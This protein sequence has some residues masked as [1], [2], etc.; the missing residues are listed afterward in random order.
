MACYVPN[1]R[2]VLSLLAGAACPQFARAAANVD[3]A[4]V[5]AVDCSYSISEY[6][7][8]LQMRGLG[9][10]FLDSEMLDLVSHGLRGKI[11]ISAFLW[12]DPKGQQLIVPWR[13]LEKAGDT[14]DIGTTLLT[15]PR[16]LNAGSTSTGSALLYAAQLLQHAP[17]GS[18]R[19]VDVSSNGHC[20]FGEPI[21]TARDHVVGQSITINGLAIDDE[22]KNM[23]DYMQTNMI[24][25]AGAFVVTA[26]DFND[27]TRAIR[28]KL[29]KEIAGLSLS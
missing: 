4:L 28:L 23:F 19:V 14:I 25:G 22:Q 8:R 12:S 9:Q 24:G 7:F 5:L 10:A 21:K 15:A 6:Q 1:R 17:S 13:V 11:A 18:R 27:Y 20:N 26:N 29:F 16:L 2:N 3:L